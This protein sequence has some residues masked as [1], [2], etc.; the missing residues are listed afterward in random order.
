MNTL[1][2]LFEHPVYWMIVGLALAGLEM[3]LPGVYILWVGLGALIVGVV[4]ALLPTLGPELQLIVFA[5]AMLASVL[6]GVRLQGKRKHDQASGLNT[7]LAA[8][9]GRDVVAEEHFHNQQGRVR[10]DDTFY[11]ARAHTPISKGS[12]VKVVGIEDGVFIVTAPSQH[13]HS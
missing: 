10:V 4:L 13:S 2:I 5:V 9:I 6:L 11:P 3:L 12:T 8:Y 7:G 1:S